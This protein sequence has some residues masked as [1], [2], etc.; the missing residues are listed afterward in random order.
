MRIKSIIAPVFIGMLFSILFMPGIASANSDRIKDAFGVNVHLRERVDEADWDTVLGKVEATG[1]QWG[2]EQFNWD[3]IEPSD[4]NYNWTT[5][6]NVLQ[7]YQDKNIEMLGLLTYS[8]S[9]ASTNPGASDSEF[10]PPD[11]DAWKDYVGKVAEHYA[12]SVDTWEIWNEPN[13]EGFWKGSLKEY[14]TYYSSAVDEIKSANP[15]AKVIL[16]GVSGADAVWLDEFFS[17][18]DDKSDI[19]VVAIHP[20]RTIDGNFNYMPERTGAG[21]NPLYVD[22]YNVKAVMNKHGFTDTPIWITEAGWTTYSGGITENMQAK[23]LMRFYTIALSI[24][25]VKKVFWYTMTDSSAD[26]SYLESQFG[27]VDHEYKPKPAYHAYKFMQRNLNRKYFEGMN[28]PEYRIIDNFVSS[29]G[30][31]F[32]ETECTSG[33]LDDHDGGTM[34]VYYN[35]TGNGNCY[36]PIALQKQ[37]PGRI[38][39]LQFKVKG[40]NDDTTLRVR[41]TDNKGE[42][43][44]Y[45][46]GYM[47]KEWLFYTIQLK[48]YQGSWGGNNDGKLDYPL[49]FDSFILDDA[50]GSLEE[51]TVYI[52]ELYAS[53]IADAYLYRFHKGHYDMYAYWNTQRAKSLLLDLTGVGQMR[54]KI[55]QKSNVLKSSGDGRFK[56]GGNKALRYLQTL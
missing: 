44:Q 27:L 50:D 1:A 35:F 5:Y 2:R 56:V 8:S 21:L 15:D 34:K 36:A 33:A 22:I 25:N 47:P 39:A 6:D 38:K 29:K 20:Y 11:L 54:V 49:T 10:Y 52:D 40:D 14:A 18:V 16:G 48:N 42:T 55:F 17:E 4:G 30:W 24:P 37:L 28:L 3:V 13:H 45:N 23:Y 9:W 46:L 51:G 43:F 7:A 31:H 53:K 26:E 12:G 32:S 41:I 19:E